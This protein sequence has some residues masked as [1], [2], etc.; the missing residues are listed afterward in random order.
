MTE[1]RYVLGD[2]DVTKESLGERS[3]SQ[4]MKKA[5][6]TEFDKNILNQ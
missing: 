5:N 2:E 1:S 6:K 4:E 3:E